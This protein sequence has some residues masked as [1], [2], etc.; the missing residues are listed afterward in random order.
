M[1]NF[2]L[3]LAPEQV[4]ILT[5]GDEEPLVNY[6]KSIVTELRAK[7]KSEVMAEILPAIRERRT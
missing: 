7:P 1:I 4:R 6:A 5:I 2:P 3:W